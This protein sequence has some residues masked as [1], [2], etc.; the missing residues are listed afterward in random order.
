MNDLLM[1]ALRCENTSRPPV[2]LMRQAG[3]YMA[4]YRSIRQNYSFLEMCHDPDLIAKITLLPINEFNMDAA[5]LFSDILIIAEAL[6]IKVQFVDGVGPVIEQPLNTQEDVDALPLPDDL[7]VS[8]KFV[9]K[10][11]HLVKK[12]LKV[13]L[14][15]FCGGPFTVASY[16]IEGKSSRDLKK[17]KQWMLR[18][19]L[20][21]HCLLSKLADWSAAYLNRQIAAGIDA[22][23]I[24]DSWAQVL[25]YPQFREF[26]L[27]YL[28]E[29]M[30]KLSDPSIPVILFCKG[31]SVFAPALAEIK[32]HAISLDW[33]C[34]MKLMRQNVSSQIALQGNL[35]PSILYAPKQTLV[36]E[37]QAL[38]QAM[39]GDKGYIFNL[40]HGIYPD[41]SEDSVRTLVNC[42]KEV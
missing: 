12:E 41:V 35:D 28:K 26:S 11:I 13:P 18:N 2:W 27:F 30:K 4:S 16:F 22:I 19:P 38:L 6:N 36:K 1:K 34:D 8:L 24:F 21:F 3:R 7:C 14:I 17:T 39:K 9:E 33:N 25:A 29:I 23:Q 10:G 31:S 42:V 15:G 37:V 40:G 32:P 5:I 20:G